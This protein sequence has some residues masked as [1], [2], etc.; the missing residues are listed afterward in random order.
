MTDNNSD[1]PQGRIFLPLN[2]YFFDFFEVARHSHLNNT[3]H[4]SILISPPF[5][6]G[7]PA[8]PFPG[9]TVSISMAE[10]N[11]APQSILKK[12]EDT[13]YQSPPQS[14]KGSAKNIVKFD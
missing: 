1:S 4:T 8:A 10:K 12:K 2:I 11:I 7:C 13:R 14:D 3:M 5:A 9:P 6:I